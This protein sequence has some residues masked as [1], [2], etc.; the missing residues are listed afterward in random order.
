[1]SALVIV[2]AQNPLVKSMEFKNHMCAISSIVLISIFGAQNLV[3]NN[4]IIILSSNH[5][6]KIDNVNNIIVASDGTTST[7]CAVCYELIDE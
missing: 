1:M 3:F 7:A 5:W 4:I 2:T 6:S